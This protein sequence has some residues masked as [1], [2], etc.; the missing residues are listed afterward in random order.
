[1]A[2]PI[3]DDDDEPLEVFWDDLRVA[4]RRA[5]PLQT[6]EV[7]RVQTQ[8]EEGDVAIGTSRGRILA[9][10]K[11]TGQIVFGPEYHP[12]EA[13]MV[14]WEAIGRRR[15]EYEERIILIQHMEALLTRLGAADLRLEGI[16]MAVTAGDPEAAAQAGG[17]LVALERLV[18]QAI[19]LGRG[20]AARPEIPVPDMPERVPDQIRQN[21]VSDYQGRA[22]I[23]PDP[24]PTGG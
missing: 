7:E 18:H 4:R 16:R 17:A 6:E 12:D 10:I 22:G 23:D 20:L 2:D 8:V 3:D 14:F 13:A 24:E 9:V 21:P 15:Y 1:M 19:E 5:P 11:P